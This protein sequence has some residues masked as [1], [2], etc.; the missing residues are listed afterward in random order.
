VDAT[1]GRVRELYDDGQGSKE[2][3]YAPKISGDNARGT[4][5][6]ENFQIKQEMR[7]SSA[8]EERKIEELRTELEKIIEES[9]SGT[10]EDG[11]ESDLGD[12]EIKVDQRGLVIEIMDT[13]KTSMF[14]SGQA[15]ILPEANNK[16]SEIAKV[17]SKV[18]NPID[19]EGH[20]DAVPFRAGR[21]YDNWNLSS[22]RAHAARRVMEAAGFQKGK[23]ARVVGYADERPRDTENPLNPANRRITISMRYTDRAKEALEGTQTNETTTSKKSKSQELASASEPV[24]PPDSATPVA[25]IKQGDGFVVS[26]EIDDLP[27]IKK[28]SGIAV[29]ISTTEPEKVER[30]SSKK[31][32]PGSLIFDSPGSFFKK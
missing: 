17:L 16:L 10:G 2:Y 21:A 12:V 30:S 26:S 31:S 27:I 32:P 14:R 20:T 18:P 13:E 15:E 22:D 1:T 8:I 7:Q 11:L 5:E 23:I 24:K 9:G 6:E 28:D 3:R 25:E 19:L 29:E 4:T